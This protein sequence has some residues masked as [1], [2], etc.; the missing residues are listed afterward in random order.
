MTPRLL[1]LFD[2][3]AES[4]VGAFKRDYLGDA[5]LRDA[6]TVLAHLGGRLDD[7]N[8]L[9]PHSALG[10]RSPREH[11]ALTAFA[12]PPASGA[13][14]PLPQD[15]RST[16]GPLSGDPPRIGIERTRASS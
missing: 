7:Y 9:A 8:T 13:P 2:G 16:A 6:E 15:G 12:A 5:E 1:I 10:M 11:R 3:L 14:P 4:F